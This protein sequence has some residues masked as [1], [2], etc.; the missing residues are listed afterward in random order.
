PA[1]LDFQQMSYGAARGF[2][3]EIDDPYTVYMDPIESKEFADG[4]D[5]KLEGIGAELEMKENQLIIVAPLKNSPAIAAGLRPGDIIVAID[6]ESTQ[7]V[8]LFEAVT[9]IRG[10]KGTQVILTIVRE[11]RD[12]AFDVAITRDSITLESVTVE[13]VTDTIY[14]VSLNQ[15]NDTT[16]REFGNAIE[17]ILLERGSG[18]ILDVRGNGGGFLDISIDI[19]SELLEGEKI[20]VIVR[21]RGKEDDFLKTS[22]NARLPDLPLVVLVDKGS[23]SAS[24]IVAGALQD[25]KRGILI[26]TQTFGKGTVQEI[27][28]LQ[29]GSSLRFTV[30]EWFT[31]KDRSIEELGIMPDIE[32]EFTEEDLKV[33]RDPQLEAAVEY[34]QNR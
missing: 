18:M 1:G 6:G 10:P 24:E 5:G 33:E 2:V 31:P 26:G 17:Q 23:A 16:R 22:G 19:L 7:D 21:E 29:D 13:P 4:L 20:A 30:A 3:S 8:G 9:K 11:G 27:K 32:V 12:E 34:L 25:Y 15:F 28:R 14:H